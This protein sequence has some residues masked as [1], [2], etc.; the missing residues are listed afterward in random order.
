MFMVMIVNERNIHDEV[1][2]DRP[3]RR[4]QPTQK[5]QV[6]KQPYDLAV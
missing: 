3:F 5:E 2:M 4:I 6:L 1:F